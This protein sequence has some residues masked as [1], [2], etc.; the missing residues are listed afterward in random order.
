MSNSVR[1]NACTKT[2][3]GSVRPKNEDAF[4]NFI[5]DG[6]E[7]ISIVCDGMG[8]LQAGELASQS[9][10]DTLEYKLKIS[11]PD[12]KSSGAV[13]DVLRDALAAANGAVHGVARQLVAGLPAEDKPLAGTTGVVVVIYQG[14]LIVAHIGDSRAY[15]MRSG[16]LMTIRSS[17]NKSNLDT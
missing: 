6:F 4:S 2:H 14:N 15:L 13:V 17:R 7:T 12:A 3:I 8:G 16:V 5:I 10:V 11:L 1:V 9:A